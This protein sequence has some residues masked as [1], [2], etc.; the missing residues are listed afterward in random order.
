M[1]IFNFEIKFIILTDIHIT[2][3]YIT[4]IYYIYNNFMLKKNNNIIYL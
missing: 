4:Y 3:T 2:Y 1:I